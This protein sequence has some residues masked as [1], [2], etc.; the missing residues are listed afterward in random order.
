[1]PMSF[2]W[3]TRWI[4]FTMKRKEIRS[5]ARTGTETGAVSF[6]WFDPIFSPLSLHALTSMNGCLIQL[7]CSCFVSYTMSAVV[8][9]VNYPNLSEW[10]VSVHRFGMR[11]CTRL[12]VQLFMRSYRM[13]K[14]WRKIWTNSRDC[15]KPTKL[16][17]LRRR[18]FWSSHMRPIRNMRMYTDMRKYP[19]SSRWD[20]D[21]LTHRLM[22][23]IS[24]VRTV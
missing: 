11:L 8:S 21:T 20:R 2:V 10:L 18:H 7:C 14:Y 4:S 19:I 13:S 15:V 3:F 12:G 16:C 1:M 5:I 9:C 22:A 17:S 24:C 23:G 6:D